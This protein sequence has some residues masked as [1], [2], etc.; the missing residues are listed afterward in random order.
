MYHEIKWQRASIFPIGES[1]RGID[2][3]PLVGPDVQIKLS[4]VLNL[5]ASQWDKRFSW[6]T[7]I[8]TCRR[9]GVYFQANDD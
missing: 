6:W 7:L 9:R 3:Y 8:S 4:I 1:L 5:L 2:N